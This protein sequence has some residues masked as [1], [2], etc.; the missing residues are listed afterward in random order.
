MEKRKKFSGTFLCLLAL[1][2][3]LA[4]YYAFVYTDLSKKT[5]GLAAQHAADTQQLAA[6]EL[7]AADK[8]ALQRSVDALEEKVEDSSAQGFGLSAPALREDL[9][10]ELASAGITATGVTAG[11]SAVWKKTSD[12]RPVT[13]ISVTVTADCTEPQLATLLHGLER[14]TDAV[15]VVDGVSMSAKNGQG[16]AGQYTAVLNLTAYSLAPSGAGS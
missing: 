5:S 3:V 2:L 4:L 6:C 12:G 13:R 11:D 8:P 1:A 16:A 15:Y 10:R 14:G 7:L 9:D